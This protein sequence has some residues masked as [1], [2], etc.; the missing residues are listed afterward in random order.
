MASNV[1]RLMVWKTHQKQKEKKT[2]K[3]IYDISLESIA[4][5]LEI[6]KVF[7]IFFFPVFFFGDDSVCVRHASI[8]TWFPNVFFVRASVCVS[9]C[10]RGAVEQSNVGSKTNVTNMGR[11]HV[12]SS[13]TQIIII[14]NLM[15]LCAERVSVLAKTLLIV[16]A[17]CKSANV[18]IFS[19][20]N[21][22]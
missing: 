13:V 12:V 1:G 5:R 3:I 16:W 15:E 8:E 18:S 19:R 22:S 20:I 11:L 21:F 6:R 10:V 2:Y 9:V 17:S 14:N 7:A 4:R